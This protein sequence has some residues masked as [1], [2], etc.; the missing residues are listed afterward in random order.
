LSER[1]ILSDAITPAYDLYLGLHRARRQNP[2][3]F[4]DGRCNAIVGAVFA[5]RAHPWRVIGITAEALEAYRKSAFSHEAAR[6]HRLRRAHLHQRIE[7]TRELLNTEE[8]LSVAHV[9]ETLWNRDMTVICARGENRKA[10][11]DYIR[12]D[13]PDYSLFA[14]RSIGWSF[15]EAEQNALRELAA[16]KSL[17]CREE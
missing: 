7:T 4:T 13:N 3:Y 1:L 5:G 15:G 9:A 14:S 16:R 17:A 6:I 11:I 10:I 8:P 12:M 2:E